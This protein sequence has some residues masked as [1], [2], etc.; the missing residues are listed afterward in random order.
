MDTLPNSESSKGKASLPSPE[1]DHDEPRGQ[2]SSLPPRPHAA[3]RHTKRLTVNFPIGPYPP[4]PDQASPSTGTM[5][6]LARSS[7]FAPSNR[8][9]A[10]LALNEPDNENDFYL[11][12]LA[13]QERKVLELREELQ[14]AEAELTNLKK[15][16]AAREKGRRRTEIVHHAEVMKPI[17]TT[18]DETA[19]SSSDS[20]RSSPPDL[21]KLALQTRMSREIERKHSSRQ[22]ISQFSNGTASSAGRPRTVF[23][24]S[25]HA[26][27][28]SLLS[29]NGAETFSH[30][31]IISSSQS[32]ENARSSTHPRSAT[33]PSI[34]RTDTATTEN[35][36]PVVSIENERNVWRHSLPITQDGTADAL[37]R[38][39]KQMASDFKDGFWTF[40]EDIRQATVGEEGINATEVRSMQGSHR[41]LRQSKVAVDRSVSKGR[42]TTPSAAARS[43]SSKAKKASTSTTEDSSF[44]SEFG[45]DSPDMKA[46]NNGISNDNEKK[47]KPASNLLD[48]DD[49]WDVWESPQPKTHTPSSSSSTFPSF[50]RDP[51]PST[52]AS[53]PRTS[54]S[55]ADLKALETD[56]ATS[57]GQTESIPWP[58]ITKLR[59]SNLTR[60]AS[61]LMEEWER[62]LSPSPSPPM[63][64]KAA[65]QVAKSD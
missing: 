54:A 43:K 28:L 15:Q 49:N 47:Q 60:T 53:S 59:P 25:R 29:P 31:Q 1:P 6:P 2:P 33:L 7:T 56:Q 21:T 11:T 36:A 34:D 32:L 65:S 23:Q 45:I 10:S 48:V 9:L 40:L 62:S 42:S 55:Y 22:S 4:Q 18:S 52:R 57:N 5:S 3:A 39:G 63:K 17:K 46:Q 50:R 20:G 24:S 37:V 51:S 12:A 14:K 38:T 61:S 8:S 27:T 44:W 64:Q 35:A 26:R 16:W 41:A 19:T 13:A 30:N 58:V